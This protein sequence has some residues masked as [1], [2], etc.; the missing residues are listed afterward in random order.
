[1][2][3]KTFLLIYILI[4][5][6]L[7]VKGQRWKLLRYDVSG[8]IGTSHYFGDIGSYSGRDF[9]NLFG[10]RDIDILGT[11]PSGF[12]G[13]RYRIR[14]RWSVKGNLVLGFFTGNDE[15]GEY[16]HRQYQFNTLIVEPSAQLEFYLIKENMIRS[17]R[18]L[19]RGGVAGI[20]RRINLY[21]FGGA[22]GVYYKTYPKGLLDDPEHGRFKE[23][24]TPFT[25]AMIG[26]MGLKYSLT[27]RTAVGIEGGARLAASDYMDGFAPPASAVPDMY[28]LG[29]ISFV[30][31]LRTLR[32]G[33]PSFR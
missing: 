22:G 21:V 18:F 30:Y 13:F 1:M 32:N 8:G 10:L 7:A 31:K 9:E 29:N 5:S 14:D 33:L 28:F 23:P 19:T 27:R 15:R 12:V 17:Y 16:P 24:S 25:V 4:F 20:K 3:R 26:G 11:R 6:V 2:S